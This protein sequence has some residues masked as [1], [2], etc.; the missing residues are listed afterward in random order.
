MRADHPHADDSDAAPEPSAAVITDPAAETK[1]RRP[2]KRALI[3]LGVLA[4]VLAVL[5]GG[6]LWFITARYAGNIARID[7]VFAGID[8][9]PRPAPATSADAPTADPVTFLLV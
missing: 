9:Q 3:A 5:I 4:L 1:R 7:D 2:L 6:G 8:E